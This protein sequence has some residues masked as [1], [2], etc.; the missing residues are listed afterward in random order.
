MAAAVPPAASDDELTDESAWGDA[1]ADSALA[2]VEG[3]GD[4]DAAELEEETYGCFELACV[5]RAVEAGVTPAELRRVIDE[6][7]RGCAKRRVE[8]VNHKVHKPPRYLHGQLVGGGAFGALARAHCRALWPL[9]GVLL[10]AG[11]D[12]TD[13]Y[14][15]KG[16]TVLSARAFYGCVDG[17]RELLRAGADANERMPGG[18]TAAHV[19]MEGGHKRPVPFNDGQLACL[20]VLVREGNCD[21]ELRDDRGRT[22][23]LM[24]QE[25]FSDDRVPAVLRVLVGELGANVNAKN[26]RDGR[27]LLSMCF[28]TGWS[29]S[30]PRALLDEFGAD[31]DVVDDDG[32]TPLMGA[33]DLL[34]DYLDEHDR[35]VLQLLLSRSSPAT[36]RAV[37]KRDGKGAIDLL[38]DVALLCAP[39][40]AGG[41]P[42]PPDWL[43]RAIDE[44]AGS[45]ATVHAGAPEALKAY[46]RT[47]GAMPPEAAGAP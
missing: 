15:L 33:C 23:L 10:L 21:L 24:L 16:L 35:E 40:T 7:S 9:A 41:P 17:V 8:A 32:A 20:A 37:R 12:H 1:D 47:I 2:G 22:V 30:V 28:T 39:A 14:E 46:A 11:A 44:L 38:L 26:A 34:V 13:V 31:P 5:Y 4:D 42:A 45:G 43:R 25:W 36:R 18:K 27:T 3:R 6:V 29:V 19:L